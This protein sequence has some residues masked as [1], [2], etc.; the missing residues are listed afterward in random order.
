MSRA[1][2]P[3]APIDKYRNVPLWKDLAGHGFTPMQAR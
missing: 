2:M 3:E 1:P